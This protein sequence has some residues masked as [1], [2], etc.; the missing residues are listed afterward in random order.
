[1]KN[2]TRKRILIIA[3]VILIFFCLV[4]LYTF[5]HEGGHALVA[6]IYGQKTDRFVLGFNAHV[7]HS[8]GNFNRTGEALLSSAGVLLPVA[9]LTVA[10]LFYNR[11]I[12]NNIYHFIYFEI[13][14][15]IISSLFAWI[16]IPVISLF[17]SPPPGDDVTRFMDAS[18]L[19]PLLVSVAAL[20]LML[21]PVLIAYKKGLISRF[22]ECIKDLG[23][24]ASQTRS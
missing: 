1:M 2:D 9:V 7:S 15:T 17:T 13:S 5:F 4:Y 8:G 12:K 21:L 3:T 24:K 11:K 19:H 20:L 16:A 14:V 22:S 6:L 23:N 10:L 18:G